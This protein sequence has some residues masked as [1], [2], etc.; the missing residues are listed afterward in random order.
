MH[1]RDLAYNKIQKMKQDENIKAKARKK[2]RDRKI[3][4][5]FLCALVILLWAGIVYGG[6]YYGSMHLQE[7]EERFVSQI[8]GLIL[9]NEQIEARIAGAMQAVQNELELSNQEMMQIQSELNLIQEELALTGETITGTDQ[10]RLS[11]QER[12]AE[13]D[14]QLA[15]LRTQLKR[16]EDAVRAF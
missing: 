10:T 13:L 6:F 8:D 12:M 3:K 16:L 1:D 4:T 2:E 5:V 9:E 11:L 14:N 15:S 7:M